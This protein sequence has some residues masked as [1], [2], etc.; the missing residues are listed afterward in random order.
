VKS[1]HVQDPQTLFSEYPIE[2]KRLAYNFIN[3]VQLRI[4]ISQCHCEGIGGINDLRALLI[5]SSTAL[6]P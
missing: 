1:E 3:L 6:R 5:S 2:L 4:A